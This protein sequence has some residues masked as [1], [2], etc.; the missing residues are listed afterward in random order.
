MNL[1]I[2]RERDGRF[3]VW[4]PVRSALSEQWTTFYFDTYQEAQ[5]FVKEFES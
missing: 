2:E 1:E 4:A 5:E 3:S